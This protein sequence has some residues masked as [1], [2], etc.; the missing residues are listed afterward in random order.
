MALIKETP[1]FVTVIG[2]PSLFKRDDGRVFPSIRVESIVVTDKLT[3][4]LW[5]LDTA[6]ATLGRI[7][8]L[9]SE[10]DPWVKDVKEKYN[11]DVKL[12][13]NLVQDAVNSIVE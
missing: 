8:L 11:P 9:K 5:M 7:E 12:Y 3:R 6:K 13:E 4:D 1:S 10:T 2:K